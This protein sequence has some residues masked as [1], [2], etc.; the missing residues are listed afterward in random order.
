MKLF[1]LSKADPKVK[2][3]KKRTMKVYLQVFYLCGC[4]KE[5]V[6]DHEASACQVACAFTA[7]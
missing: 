2:K 3:E 1:I 6:W 4:Y 5:Y 7:L